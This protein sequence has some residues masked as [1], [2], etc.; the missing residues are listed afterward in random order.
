M[1][2]TVGLFIGLFAGAGLALIGLASLTSCGRDTSWLE[3][4]KQGS[5]DTTD[6]LLRWDAEPVAN[7][8][9][10]KLASKQEVPDDPERS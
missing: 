2:F 7:C 5:A 4:Y 10:Y 3:G 1:T 9:L 8:A 6:R